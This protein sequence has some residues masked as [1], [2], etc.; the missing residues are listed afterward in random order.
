MGI[1]M[2]EKL[3]KWL[4]NEDFEKERQEY[5]RNLIHTEN[6]LDKYMEYAHNLTVEERSN[7]IQKCID[8][9][10]SDVYRDREYAMGR[11]PL[12]T[13][14]EYIF[15][16]GKRYGVEL[17]SDNDGFSFG[18]FLI[19]DKFIVEEFIGQG[20]FISVWQRENDEVV[21]KNIKDKY[22]EVFKPNGEMLVRTNDM[23]IF[24][25]ILVQI[26]EKS[27]EGYYIKF[28]G[29]TFPI[30]KSGRVKP[31]PSGLFSTYGEQLRKLCGF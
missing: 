27:L 19:D 24:T 28:E 25:D 9:Y 6:L 13:L 31:A 20:N 18:K 17:L 12:R 7:F 10:E 5:E 14:Y 3:E 4:K 1:K 15:E 30:L 16:Y 26:H 11:E 2:S 21:I 23:L 8:K 29:K 22:C